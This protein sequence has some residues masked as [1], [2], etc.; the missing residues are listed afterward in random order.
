MRSKGQEGPARCF[1]ELGASDRG[2][3]RCKGHA[4]GEGSWGQRWAKK[5]PCCGEIETPVEVEGGGQILGIVYMIIY[6]TC[7]LIFKYSVI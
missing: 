6:V 3:N 7:T 5:R 2:S 1:S 4:T